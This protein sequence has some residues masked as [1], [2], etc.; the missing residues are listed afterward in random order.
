MVGR[1]LLGFAVGLSVV[2]ECSYIA[3]ISSPVSMHKDFFQF[4]IL[5]PEKSAEYLF[6]PNLANQP[7]ELINWF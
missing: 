3:E 2:A 6:V 7:T 4:W 1:I 5:I